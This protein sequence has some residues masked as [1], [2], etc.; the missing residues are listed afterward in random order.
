[1]LKALKLWELI[2]LGLTKEKARDSLESEISRRVTT[3]FILDHNNETYVLNPNALEAN[4]HIDEVLDEAYNVGRS[5]N[6]MQNNFDLIKLHFDNKNYT[7]EVTFTDEIFLAFVDQLQN[8]FSD[9]ISNASYVVEDMSLIINKG[10]DGYVIDSSQLKRDIEKELVGTVHENNH[11]DLPVVWTEA[12]GINVRKIHD[13]VYIAPVDATFTTNPY[14]I[15]AS[16]TGLDF[17][18]SL[19]EAENLVAGVVA[20]ETQS[21]AV[22]QLK[23]LYPTVT[24]DN[25]GYDAFPNELSSY[26]T[27][28]GSISSY[29]RATNIELCAANIDGKV[30]MPGEVFSF[31]EVV[32]QRTPQRGF[33]QAAAYANGQ[34]VMEY[35]GGICQ[36]S[37]TLYNAVLLAN[38]EIVERYNHMFPVS[39]VPVSRDATVSWGSCDF[40]FKNNKNYPIKI[41]SKTSDGN[42]YIKIYGIREDNEPEVSI[43]SYRTGSTSYG[44]YSTAVKIQ[45]LN[46]EEISRETLSYDYYRNH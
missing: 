42:V 20:D 35:G 22:I 12:E 30:F 4:F 29:G 18:M 43:V 8:R 3:D 38:L 31:N 15:T 45:K 13:E 11:L 23:T 34:T 24:T 26:S 14:K 10:H 46:G 27:H 40:L 39:Y 28:Y 17:N 37:S 21:Q 32:G 2:F 44:F 19:E 7:P 41:S 5:K 36:V 33:K 1:M 25:L 9:C 6:I 16:S